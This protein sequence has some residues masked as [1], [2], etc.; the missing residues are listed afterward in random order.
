[1]MICSHMLIPQ[2]LFGLDTSPLAPMLKLTWEGEVQTCMQLIKCLVKKLLTSQRIRPAF[3]MLL[4]LNL[5]PLINWEFFSITMLWLVQENRELLKTITPKFS[6]QCSRTTM[7]SFK[8]WMR[9]LRKF[10]PLCQP[11]VNGN[12]VS[13]RTQL[14]LTAL[15]L[16][17]LTQPILWLPLTILQPIHQITWVYPSNTLF[18]KLW[19]TTTLFNNSSQLAVL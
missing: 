12:G 15:L 8:Y 5:L 19:L 3:W 13:R 18:T 17:M 9:F 10:S 4:M 2:L 14:I 1:M 7:L 6:A 16:S 11:K